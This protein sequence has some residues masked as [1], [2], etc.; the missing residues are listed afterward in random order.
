MA[1]R[2]KPTAKDLY[3]ADFYVWARNQ[4]E[5]LRD[6][7]FDELDLANLI[8]EVEDLAGA[9]RRSARNRTIT[10]MVHLLK[11]QY[12]PATEPRLGWRETILT[13]RTRLLTDLTPTLRR[14][15][16]GERSDAYIRARHDAEDSLRDHGDQDAADA[17][18]VTCPY[19]LDPITGNWLP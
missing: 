4:A 9:M 12:S 17:L 10:I 11:L 15:L 19:T 14:E 6:K 18:P 7:R 8:E 5:L 3:E 2:I 1:T 13:Q 16:A